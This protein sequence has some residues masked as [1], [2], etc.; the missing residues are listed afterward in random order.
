MVIN[1]QGAIQAK[2]RTQLAATTTTVTGESAAQEPKDAV[3][4][5]FKERTG[6]TLIRVGNNWKLGLGSGA[7]VVGSLVGGWGG[8]IG[9]TAVG[10]AIGGA[11]SG[12]VAAL[13]SEGIVGFFRTALSTAATASFIGGACGAI[14]GGVGGY[15]LGK[16]AIGLP[17]LAAQKLGSKMIGF[18]PNKEEKHG[19][20]LGMNG[21][22]QGVGAMTIG[23]LGAVPGALGGVA[24]GGGFGALT[25]LLSNGFN[26]SAL[27]GAGATGA[28]IGGAVGLATGIA[29]GITVYN[30]IRRGG[31]AF[32]DG[33]KNAKLYIQTDEKDNRLQEYGKELKEEAGKLNDNNQAA[34]T[35]H[36][37]RTAN[38][39]A[40][41]KQLVESNQRVDYKN[42][43]VDKLSED[44]AQNLYTTTKDGLTKR[45]KGQDDRQV[46]LDAEDKRVNGRR[47]NIQSEI[48]QRQNQL[49]D[50][51][52][53]NLESA[54]QKR[55]GQLAD[56]DRELDRKESQI[57]NTVANKVEQTLQPLRSER[58]RI[59]SSAVSYQNKAQ[60]LRIQAQNDRNEIPGILQ[61]ADRE[62]DLAS[63]ARRQAD[64]LRPEVS[65]LN[66]EV[67]SLRN[68]NERRKS[69]LDRREQ[70]LISQGK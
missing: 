55:Q 15:K 23:V 2:T 47:E 63:D 61:R 17:G 30:G 10:A 33:Q 43:N 6:A 44:R 21:V 67:S 53:N 54:Y 68:E 35:E 22:M 69:D 64:N 25:S 11:L 45:E 39:D 48:D 1:Q 9:G 12:S 56:K 36:K 24:L 32:I 41:D 66:S 20:M 8:L 5:S 7:G 42:A 70:I 3:G 38:L 49:Y 13:T 46:H 50:G 37:D 59:N 18:D 27:T 60:S 16:S 29:G 62:R 28:L 14:T 58:D 52:K 26:M 31:G 34:S 57:P 65:S 51:L 19:T 40:R 4:T